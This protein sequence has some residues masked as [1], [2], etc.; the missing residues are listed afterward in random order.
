MKKLV[1]VYSGKNITNKQA[2]DLWNIGV[3]SIFSDDPRDLLFNFNS[4]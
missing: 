3:D 4:F 1:T 2:L